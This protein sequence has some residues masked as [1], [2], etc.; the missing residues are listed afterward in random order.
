MAPIV[1]VF[2]RHAPR[3]KEAVIAAFNASGSHTLMC[4]DGTND[5]GALKQAHVGVSIISVPDLEAKQR[6]ANETISAVRAE[7]KKERKSSKKR[8]KSG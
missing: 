7:D 3:H 1:S 8:S 4:G 2:A 6:S 5:V